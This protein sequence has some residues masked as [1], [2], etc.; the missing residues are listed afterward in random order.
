MYNCKLQ[1]LNLIETYYKCTIACSMCLSPCYYFILYMQVYSEIPV[2]DG[3]DGRPGSKEYN[4]FQ[5]S[6]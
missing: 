1:I 6:L 4:I 3:H 2:D 5:L